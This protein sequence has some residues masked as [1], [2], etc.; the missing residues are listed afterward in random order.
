[1]SEISISGEKIFEIAGFSV[2][3]TFFLSLFLSLVIFLSFSIVFR[4]TSIIPNKIQNFFEF[5]LESFYNFVDS[6]TSSRELTREIFPLSVT[7]FILILFSNLIELIPG[8]GVFPFL[9]SPSSDLNFTFALSSF[10]ML[11]VNFMALRRLG[12]VS[13]LK[14]FLNKNPIMLFVGVLEGLGELTRAFSLAMRLFGNLFAGEI[15][16][17]VI[18]SLFAYIMPLPFLLL[19]IIVGFIQAFIFSS[20]ITIFYTASVQTIH[21][22]H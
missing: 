18:S 19:E 15:L 20:L 17:M 7:L 11:Y 16:L 6:I 22:E 8:V 3:N 14:R 4:K 13:Y 9:R 2:T 12:F 21:G 5:I 10:S 1:M